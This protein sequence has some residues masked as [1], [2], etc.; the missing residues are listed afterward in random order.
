MTSVT[1]TMTPTPVSTPDTRPTRAT[2]VEAP[3]AQSREEQWLTL[4]YT[5]GA[6]IPL[7]PGA[8]QAVDREGAVSDWPD[9]CGAVYP[10]P[11]VRLRPAPGGCRRWTVVI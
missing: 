9:A 1:F 2:T 7:Q 11:A 10:C 8:W 5:A 6:I 4:P 3:P